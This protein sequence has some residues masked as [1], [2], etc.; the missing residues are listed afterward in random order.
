MATQ[1]VTHEQLKPGQRV[2][3]H[4]TIDRRA[5]D[6]QT[7]TEGVIARVEVAPTGSWYAH[8][9]DGRLWLTRVE[10][11]KDGGERTRLNLDIR[12]QIELLADAP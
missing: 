2:R 11:V 8:G 12:S 3:V 4:Q 10:L 5:G 9:K 7:A 1:I 6:W